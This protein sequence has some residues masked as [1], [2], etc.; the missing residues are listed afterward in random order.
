MHN[1]ALM[2]FL[3]VMSMMSFVPSMTGDMRDVL[4]Y[5]YNYGALF[6]MDLE[7]VMSMVSLTPLMI[8]ISTMSLIDKTS[9]VSGISFMSMISRF[10]DYANDFCDVHVRDVYDRKMNLLGPEVSKIRLFSIPF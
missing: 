6:L 7:T 1:T 8:I 10:K 2:A 3:A 5:L 9:M 4:G